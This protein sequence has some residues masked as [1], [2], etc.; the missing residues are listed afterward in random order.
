MEVVMNQR[1]T[2]IPGAS[3]WDEYQTDCGVVYK[4]AQYKSKNR[5]I[6]DGILAQYPTR[7]AAYAALKA[8]KESKS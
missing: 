8:K 6:A 2:R 1:Y 4:M 3:H 7:A 5:W